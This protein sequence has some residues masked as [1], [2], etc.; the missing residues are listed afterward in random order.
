[1]WNRVRR[2]AWLSCL[3]LA[4][5]SGNEPRVQPCTA[6]NSVAIGALPLGGYGSVDPGDDGCAL[7]SANTEA[8]TI[9]YLVV[10]QSVASESNRQA[11][12]R[13]AGEAML[14]GPATAVF[15]ALQ[16]RSTPVSPAEQFHNMLRET[17]GRRS[18]AAA[19]PGAPL[20]LN[21]TQPPPQVGEQRTFKVCSSLSCFPPMADVTGVVKTVGTHL[22]LYVDVAAQNSLSQADYDSITAVFDQRLF[23]LDTM[24]FGTPSDRDGNGLVM[25]LLTPAINR[26]V[27]AQ[28]CMTSGFVAGYFFGNDLDPRLDSDAN[29]N[30]G[31]LFYSLVPDPTGTY[32]CTH[33]VARVKQII[34]VVLVHELQHMVSFNHHVLRPGA[35]TAR[36][37]VLWLNEALSHYA[38]ELGGRSYLPDDN[39][40]FSSYLTG[41]I[42]NAYDYLSH[43]GDHFLVANYGSGT[44][45]E[46]GAGWLFVRYLVDQLATDTSM[47]AWHAVTRELIQTT[48]QGP[49][50]VEARTGVP[51]E[52][53]LARW[54]LTLWVSDLPGF[55]TPPE[56]RFRS[57]RFRTTYAALAP[58][59]FEREYPLEPPVTSGP[60]VNIEGTLRS[61]SGVYERVLHPPGAP[62]FTL[63]LANTNGAPL[64]PSLVPRLTVIRVR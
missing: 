63:Q 7:F 44:L 33:S 5:N 48:A 16:A 13:L 19:P 25:V 2:M 55:A 21:L 36:T 6:E 15:A 62:S 57:W 50:N 58:S 26:L 38:E 29:F 60:D 45:G 40:T 24:A 54:A 37:E 9:E 34:P 8:D 23:P 32:S 18:Y 46:R 3:G 1:M 28:Q 56:L 61:G 52:Q 27:T 53:T 39:P 4:C 20:Q 49:A 10:A 14:A 11:Q 31:E 51:F 17:E 59:I 42:R 47:A 30:K 12:F 64:H 22:A 41:N 43:S 35:S